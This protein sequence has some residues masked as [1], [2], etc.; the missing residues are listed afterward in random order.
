MQDPWPLVKV[1]VTR[2][3]FHAAMEAAV[4]TGQLAPQLKAHKYVNQRQVVALHPLSHV[5][6]PVATQDL[7][8]LFKEINFD[9]NCQEM[10]LLHSRQ[11]QHQHSHL[12]PPPLPLPSLLQSQPPPL[13]P[14]QV[15]PTFLALQLHR[16]RLAPLTLSSLQLRQ[17]HRRWHPR[18]ICR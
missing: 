4:L 6:S 18:N 2:D 10:V 7:H 13:L 17:R 14:C 1:S 15:Q 5:E 9:V 3:T 16:V 12:H 8:V 11:F